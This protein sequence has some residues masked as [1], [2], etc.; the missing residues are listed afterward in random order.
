M[1]SRTVAASA[2]TAT[3][4][5]GRPSARARRAIVAITAARMTLGSGV[6]RITNA[7]RTITAPTMRTPRGAPHAARRAKAAATTIAQLAPETAVRWDSDE[8]F[9][10]SSVAAS[11]IEVSPTARPGTSPAPG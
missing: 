9:M 2:S 6:T 10:A 8:A 4:T 3:P 5:A 7:A 1:T 11:S